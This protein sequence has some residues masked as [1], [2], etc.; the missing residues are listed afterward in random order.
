MKHAIPA[1][2][3]LALTGCGTVANVLS[4]KAVSCEGLTT[5]SQD[6]DG[7]DICSGKEIDTLHISK[8]TK[9]GE[10]ILDATGIR[11]F[12]GQALR[13]ETDARNIENMGKLIDRIPK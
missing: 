9:D 11:A 10:F 5:L 4:D 7:V 1:L 2:T 8:K 13:A 12:D 6:G 3:L